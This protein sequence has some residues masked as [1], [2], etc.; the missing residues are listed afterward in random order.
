MDWDR[1]SDDY[2]KYRAGPPA[3]YFD[4][5]KEQGVG[6]PG[7]RL[8]DFGTGTGVLARNFARAGARVSG[9]DSS[10]GQIE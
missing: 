6:L 4:R 2:A 10:P 5:L 8:L 7:Q 1:V 3:S 9:V